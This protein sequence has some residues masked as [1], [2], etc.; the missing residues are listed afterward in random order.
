MD[1]PLASC[2]RGFLARRRR[3]LFK[4]L[5]R[6]LSSYV[7]AWRCAKIFHARVL[8]YVAKRRVMLEL[9]HVESSYVNNLETILVKFYRPMV[10]M[11]L[12]TQSQADDLFPGL[13]DMLYIHKD[14]LSRVHKLNH[15]SHPGGYII[16]ESL[17]SEDFISKIRPLYAHYITSYEHTRD[18]LRTNKELHEF[19]YKQEASG[20]YDLESLLITPVQR[21]PRYAHRMIVRSPFLCSLRYCLLLNTLQKRAKDNVGEQQ[22]ILQ[23]SHKM[24]KLSQMLNEYA[25]NKASQ[26]KLDQVEGAYEF[27]TKLH[28]TPLNTYC[29]DENNDDNDDAAQ[30][31][32][33]S[34]EFKIEGPLVLCRSTPLGEAKTPVYGFLFYDYFLYARP[35]SPGA[36]LVRGLL[37]LHQYKLT[38]LNAYRTDD[39]AGVMVGGRDAEFLVNVNNKKRCFCLKNNPARDVWLRAFQSCIQ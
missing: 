24:T 5:V 6:V 10:Q 37:G 29:G 7:R 27:L 39:I 26:S 28:A 23:I 19:I 12:V 14:L 16:P 35:I 31:A 36:N 11:N 22:H 13:E 4:K 17:F 18:F 1:T 15:S 30:D 32:S 20:G 21:L 8:T 9:E 34:S 33:S 3:V 25:R 2:C 38:L